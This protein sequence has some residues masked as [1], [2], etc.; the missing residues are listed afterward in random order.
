LPILAVFELWFF[1][2]LVFAKP[3]KG[4]KIASPRRHRRFFPLKFKK[5]RIPIF[6]MAF[7]FSWVEFFNEE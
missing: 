3:A 1:V 2:A 7:A 6:G 5:D 4:I